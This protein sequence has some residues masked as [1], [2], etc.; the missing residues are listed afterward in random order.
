MKYRM[1]ALFLGVFCFY[2]NANAQKPLS[3]F[4]PKTTYNNQI[5]TPES[6][7]G[8]QVGEYH[9]G[10]DQMVYYMKA[11]ANASDR[12]TL[13][14]YAKSYEGRPLLLL[15][16]TSPEN[17]NN[18]D[19][20]K[21]NHIGRLEG[22][23]GNN[24]GPLIIYQGYSVH[25]NESSGGNASLLVAYHLAAAQ[26]ETTKK[27][28]DET[29]VLIDP[30]MNPDGFNRFAHWVN[31]NK[32]HTLVSDPYN[33]EQN[34]VWPGGRTNHYWFDLNRDWLPVQH[35]E[36]Q[37][38][39]AN[40][41][42]WKPN[43]LTDFHEMG[44]NATY[45]FQPGIPARTNALTPEK[46]Q[47][48]T[49]KIAEYHAKALDKIGS[50]YYTRESFDDYYYGKGS[51][52][53]D[54]NGCVGILFEQA[55]SR[56]HL[57]ESINGMVSFPF[58]IKNQVTTSFSTIEAGYEMRKELLDFQYNFYKNAS[59]KLKKAKGQGYIVEAIDD[60][61]RLYL[62]LKMVDQHKIKFYKNEKDVNVKG[63]KFNKNKSYV[64]PFNQPQ[65]RLIEAMFNRPTKF[66]D[67][68]FYDVSAFTLPLSFNLQ[69]VEWSGSVSGDPAVLNFP[70]GK[71]IQE[72]NSY[73]YLFEW[74]GYYAPRALNRL[75][76]RGISA[77][78]ATKP[79]KMKI[80]DELKSFDYGTILIP[81]GNSNIRSSVKRIIK[82]INIKD[83]IDVYG[84]G[85]GL[86]PEGIDLGSNSFN[87]LKPQKVGLLT[88]PSVRA[89]DAG[90]VWHLL[91]RRYEMPVTHLDTDRLR[92]VDLKSYTTIIISDGWYNFS[93]GD[94]KKLVDWVKAGGNLVVLKNAINWAKTNG[95]A[96]VIHKVKK[97]NKKGKK[98]YASVSNDRGAQVI[99]GAI[100]EA[101][102]DLTHPLGYGYNENKIPVF[103]RGTL[104]FEPA[105]NPYATPLRYTNDPLLA[106]YISKEN[107]N[108]IK[109][110]ASII[111]SGSGSGRVICL[112]DNPNFRAFWHGTDKLMA[113]A[114]F[115]GHTI[116][117]RT[118]E[119]ASSGK[120]KEEEEEDNGHGHKH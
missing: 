40:F 41:H 26:D 87:S 14:E 60:P 112:A 67:S 39:I 11:L 88:G 116:S 28:L 101:H 34:E 98:P 76:S 109:N 7:L 63:K 6:V 19:K 118:I 29:V 30:C 8:Y 91:D 105:K 104:F 115:F 51:T 47:E 83:G 38:R 89:Y 54:I 107:A 64:I 59:S 12:V 82:D 16:I 96:G 68:L 37:G 111:I 75:L 58:T 69:H 119:P 106:G 49:G 43:I 103:R 90:E 27:W 33:R 57:Q 45:F 108:V 56:G 4:L 24:D 42:E 25:G 86:T 44:S 20:I 13:K 2:L 93:A 113:N 102:L 36:S 61:V 62:F 52:Y 66:K 3:Y 32:S 31:A 23:K 95:L 85:T 1:I 22:K 84:V 35:P 80:G 94:S 117:S 99:G 15:T 120:K 48:L 65:A 78:V 110:S 46:N 77:K 10:H 72:E 55:S 53:P 100:F 17:H 18:I 114:I 92:R 70:E 21:E 5:P 97:N 81:T 50:L 71:T 9:V 79:F 73:A 74:D